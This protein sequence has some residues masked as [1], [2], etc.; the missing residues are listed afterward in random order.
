MEYE[1]MIK[2]LKKKLKK[3]SRH[4]SYSSNKVD[5]NFDE[6]YDYT[7]KLFDKILKEFTNEQLEKYGLVHKLQV[8][9]TSLKDGIVI[10][11]CY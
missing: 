1:L 3:K 2:E 6:A 9:F 5:L 8:G 7:E 4:F 10:I 11:V